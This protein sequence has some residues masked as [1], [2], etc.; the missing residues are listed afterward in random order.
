MNKLEVRILEFNVLNDFNFLSSLNAIIDCITLVSDSSAA[1]RIRTNSRWE[2]SK[3]ILS[4][5]F[6]CNHMI[7]W[8]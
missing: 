2:I 6:A 5:N 7:A 8:W 3:E 4:M 1:S